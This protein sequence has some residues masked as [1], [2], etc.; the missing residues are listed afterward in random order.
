[1][2]NVRLNPNGQLSTAHTNMSKGIHVTQKG[3]TKIV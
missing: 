1:M 3:C 2:R